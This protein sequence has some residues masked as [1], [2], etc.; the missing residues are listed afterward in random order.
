MNKE[1]ARYDSSSYKS[2]VEDFSYKVKILDDQMFQNE[3]SRKWL[4]TKLENLANYSN[5]VAIAKCKECNNLFPELFS[6]PHTMRPCI[7]N[8]NKQEKRLMQSI[9]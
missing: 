5:I 2:T 4:K 1:Y 8:M 7:Q 6:I 3:F 9:S